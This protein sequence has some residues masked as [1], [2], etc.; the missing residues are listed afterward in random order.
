[1]SIRPFPVPS[2]VLHAGDV[3]VV[4]CMVDHFVQVWKVNLAELVFTDKFGK[5]RV[6]RIDGAVLQENL[7]TWIFKFV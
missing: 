6:T 4:G 7:S 3:Q 5:V 1:M 2:D